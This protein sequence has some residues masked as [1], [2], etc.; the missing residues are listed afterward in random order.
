MSKSL[1]TRTGKGAVLSWV[2]GDAN[3]VNLATLFSAPTPPATIYPLMLWADTT[4][5]IVKQRNYA[6]TAWVPLWKFTG[7][8]L[9]AVVAAEINVDTTSISGMAPNAVVT[10]NSSGEIDGTVS[11]PI[12]A[13][14]IVG[15]TAA[16]TLTNKTISGAENTITGIPN[17]G[18]INASVG[19]NGQNLFLG[20][21][22]NLVG[23]GTKLGTNGK[24]DVDFS[25]NNPA[26]LGD[27]SPGA[28]NFVS[29]ADHVHPAPATI[30]GNAA[31]ATS[32]ATARTI[33]STGDVAFSFLFDGSSNVNFT[34]T[35]DASFLQASDNNVFLGT[36]T[37][38]NATGQK[39]IQDTDKDGILIRGSNSGTNG[40]TTELVPASLTANRTVTFPD[41]N[42]TVV[43]S[44]S[45]GTAAYMNVGDLPLNYITEIINADRTLTAGD[46]GK[47]FLVQG[48]NIDITLPS[49]AALPNGWMVSIYNDNSTNTPTT[50]SSAVGTIT[51][52]Q[53]VC[54]IIRQGT[55]TVD[56]S[57]ASVLGSAT[58]VG[59]R[60]TIDI[61][62]SGSGT[63]ASRGSDRIG[64]K[65]IVQYP[66]SHSTNTNDPTE[67]QVDASFIEALEFPRNAARRVQAAFHIN[68]DY[69]MGTPVYLHCHWMTGNTTNSTDTVRFSAI[70]S[71][72]KGHGQQAFDP[73]GTTVHM[74]KQLNGTPYTHYISEVGDADVIPPANLEPDSLILTRYYRDP[75]DAVDTYTGSVWLLMTDCHYL[76]DRS[77]TPSKSPTFYL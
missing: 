28:S 20:S 57:G 21:S 27:A 62:K 69:M 59:P 33:S 63:F 54:R 66:M 40:Y 50:H 51:Y 44:E 26:P 17:S 30:T 74:D 46:A 55:D 25:A 42:I 10:T 75:A 61:W 16:Q 67:S 71:V 8:P 52:S 6:N 39:F 19:I 45:L 38:K 29:R 35:V 68:H 18:L 15:T 72:A 43:G 9:N 13:G 65:D 14:D 12:P 76:S 5:E 53:Q 4:D 70:H 32:L 58:F 41:A 37:F 31:T 56:G 48:A 73:T 1:V 47:V 60:Q 36:N 24:I 77:V 2:E 22:L 11:F 64:W 3:I 49:A 7:E 23:N 34:S